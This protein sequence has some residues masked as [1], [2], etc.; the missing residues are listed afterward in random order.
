MAIKKKKKTFT[1]TFIILQETEL[2]I[3][4]TA[5]LIWQNMR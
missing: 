4:F 3:Y 1:S 5:Q 2:K